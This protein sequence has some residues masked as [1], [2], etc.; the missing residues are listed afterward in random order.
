MISRAELEEVASLPARIQRGWSLA[1][2][3]D[4]GRKVVETYLTRVG[5]MGLALLTT[6]IVSRLLGPSGR[7]L[8]AIAVA[9][10]TMGVQFGNLGLH[11]SNIYFAARDSSLLPQLTGN[12]LAVSFGFG[13]LLAVLI[14]G[15]LLASP[16]LIDLRGATLFLALLWIPFGLAYLLLQDL[17]LGLQDVRGYN[18][19]EAASKAIPL[20]FIA[21]L[22]AFGRISVAA[23]FATTV[24]ALI[25]NC[26]WAFQRLQPHLLE[27]PRISREVFRSSFRYAL[28]AYL[29]T[30][31][32][33]LVLRADLFM[34]QHMRGPEQAGYYSIASTMADYVSVVAVIVGIIL[35]PK[36]S[37]LQDIRQKLGLTRKAVL[38]TTAVL[39]PSLGIAAVL[40]RPIVRLLF[41]EAFLPAAFAFA[42]LMPGM[43]FLGIHSVAVQFLNSIGF[44]MTVVYIWGTCTIFN[45][46][47]NLWA[48]PTHGIAGASI[49]SS[50]SYFFA[51]AAVM[52]VIRRTAR[53]MGSEA[54][55]PVL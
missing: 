42:L 6:V 5:I 45:I 1:W 3:S 2:S 40:A 53:R 9:T 13:S 10:G 47:V 37:A 28:K 33:F 52:Q 11:V 14:G 35:L 36:I 38:A 44:P 43:L 16:G 19:L 12:S 41:G 27:P 51:F 55:A 32:C 22:I 25:G 18:L 30:S 29:T 49:V 20:L 4:F 31:F 50:I 26:L 24:V 23:L 17:M 15:V 7:G 39:L 46:A 54:V 34:V 21:V 48:I 8:Y